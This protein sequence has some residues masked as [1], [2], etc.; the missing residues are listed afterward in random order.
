MRP[1]KDPELRLSDPTDLKQRSKVSFRVS[2]RGL[3]HRHGSC[4]KISRK[5]SFDGPTYQGL[6]ICLK[7]T[8]THSKSF[9]LHPEMISDQHISMGG[10]WLKPPLAFDP[11]GTFLA[12]SLLQSLQHPRF[13]E[14]PRA[15]HTSAAT[16]VGHKGHRGHTGHTGHTGQP[17][18]LRGVD[19]MLRRW[20]AQMLHGVFGN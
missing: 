20:G 1:K 7:I 5:I 16:V 4:I 6:Q 15:Q 13:V 3:L 11:I 12:H 10:S 9:L 17:T 19:A 2:F 18:G 8:Q 14:T